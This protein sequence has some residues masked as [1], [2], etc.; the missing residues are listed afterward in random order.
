MSWNA[1]LLSR[2]TCLAKFPSEEW[3]KLYMEQVNA[4]KSYEDAA[5][6]WEGDFLFIVQADAD[7]KET[8]TMYMDLWHG[9]CRNAELVKPGEDK[10]AAFVFSGP[11]GNWKKLITTRSDPI[12]GLLTGKFKL[13]G[14]MAKVLRAVR[15]AKELVETT[16]K[17]PTDWP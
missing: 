3:A 13:Q 2:V 14:D 15:A 11:Y 8:A 6:T 4:N 1:L 9:K 16:S 5:K 7:L 10:K 12:Q 17:V